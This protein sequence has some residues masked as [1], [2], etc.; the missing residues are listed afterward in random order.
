MPELDFTAAV[1]AVTEEDD[2]TTLFGP[3]AGD[4]SAARKR[5]LALAKALHPDT[6]GDSEKT[7]AN[8]AFTLLGRRWREHRD[9]TRGTVTIGG[10]THR[11]SRNPRMDDIAACYRL[12]DD[13]GA[14]G[15]E[16]R[17]ARDPA[18]NDL[19]RAEADALD[20]I[21]AEGDPKFA[22]Y[23]PPRAKTIRIKDDATGI[24]R[25][26]NVLPRPDGFVSLRDV[27][28][29]Y[30]DGLHPKDAA[31]MWRRLLVAIGQAHRC[32]IVHGAV[33]PEHVLIHPEQHGLLLTDWYYA[34]PA[35]RRLSAVAA[36]TAT[37]YPAEVF[38]RRPVAASLDIFM[39]TRCMTGLIGSRIPA[40]LERFARGCTLGNARARPRD[41][42]A[43]LAELDDVL[44][45][46]WGPR[47]FRPF[48]MPS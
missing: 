34:V 48:S 39:A 32:G 21:A 16:L 43:L 46:L 25:C 45:R 27:A 14:T 28:D 8:R 12:Y 15:D 11:L 35:G 24:E 38:N 13:A 31:W 18:D 29:G 4:G 23:A 47:V 6:V 2:P 44:H 19:I 22:A 26:G 30:P 5:Y 3:R 40:E 33:I 42:W 36:H 41:A 20:R 37:A 1:A 9:D 17:L 7:T 10:T